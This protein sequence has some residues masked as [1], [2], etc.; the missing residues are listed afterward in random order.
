MKKYIKFLFVILCF[1]FSGCSIDYETYYEKYGD[2]SNKKERPDSF[3]IDESITS[4]P[5]DNFLLIEKYGDVYADLSNQYEVYSSYYSSKYD[6]LYISYDNINNPTQELTSKDLAMIEEHL[7][8]YFVSDPLR[9][10]YKEYLKVV[11]IYPDYHSSVCRS[12][13]ASEEEYSSIEGCA[14]YDALEASINLNGLN[15]LERFFNPYTY[16][17]GNFQYYTEPKRDTFAHEFG[18]VATYYYLS[19]KGDDS[20]EDYLRLRLGEG[21]DR[22][23]KDGLPSKYDSS[24]SY[25]IQPV[26]ILADD[27]VELYYSVS[28]KHKLDSYDYELE[29]EDLRNSLDGVSG[30][31]KHLKEDQDLFNEVKT[32]FDFVINNRV[33]NYA[34]PKVVEVTGVS[35]NTIH[36]IVNN[37][38]YIN[39]ENLN[40]I[41]LGEVT[42]NGN[43]YYK[44]ILS[45][46]VKE[47]NSRRDY[48]YNVGYVLKEN[49]IDTNRGVI[50]FTKYDN[51]VLDTSISYEVDAYYIMPHY[52]FSYFIHENNIVK[53][54][55]YLEEDFT[56]IEMNLSDFL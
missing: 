18:H 27:Y 7:L 32:Y 10:E 11:R 40:L 34:N 45:N 39:L 47:L 19:L 8:Y 15:S 30:V 16:V 1:V 36:N 44:V 55:N 50:K 52:D 26:E 56:V 49:C 51:E 31:V 17:S 35:F 24:D 13:E 9:L 3:Y 41:A 54:Y 53:I 2:I 48:T 5:N 38:E 29:Y 43:S 37:K 46:V 22:I 4:Y 14:L 20:Y 25:Y 21:F 33:I 28:E 42:I 6:T 12:E 23:Y